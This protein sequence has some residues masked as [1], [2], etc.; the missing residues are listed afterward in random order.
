MTEDHYIHG[1]GRRRRARGGDRAAAALLRQRGGRR[2]RAED[3][4]AGQGLHLGEPED[5]RRGVLL[6]DAAREVL[7]AAGFRAKEGE[8]LCGNY[9]V[10]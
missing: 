9:G 8:G 2:R 7:A 5:E 1:T 6:E 3:R 4:A 10:I